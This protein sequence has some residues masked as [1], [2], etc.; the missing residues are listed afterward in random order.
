MGTCRLKRLISITHN[1]KQLNL[2]AVQDDFDQVFDGVALM[3]GLA[4][5]EVSEEELKI[6]PE[7]GSTATK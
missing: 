4:S 7:R 5:D 3:K 1:M 2:E 6:W